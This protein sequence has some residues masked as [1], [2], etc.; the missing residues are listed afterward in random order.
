MCFQDSAQN[1]WILPMWLGENSKQ[2]IKKSTEKYQIL[3]K[4]E[5]GQNTWAC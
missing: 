5:S 3:I 2:I 1:L 4:S